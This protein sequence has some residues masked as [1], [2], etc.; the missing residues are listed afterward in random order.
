LRGVKG[1]QAG[2]VDKVADFRT[3]S[4]RPPI[5]KRNWR[6]KKRTEKKASYEKR[7]NTES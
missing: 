3:K 2:D 7:P 5:P 1:G 6:G 4:C